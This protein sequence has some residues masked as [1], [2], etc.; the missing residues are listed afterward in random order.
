MGANFSLT[1]DTVLNDIWISYK[2]VS[3]RYKAETDHLQI[4]SYALV[5]LCENRQVTAILTPNH[6]CFLFL[7]AG[8]ILKFSEAFLNELSLCLDCPS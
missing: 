3:V 2:I 6:F 7:V 1:F 5:T 8:G 4:T